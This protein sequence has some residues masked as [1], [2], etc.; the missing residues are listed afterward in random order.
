MPQSAQISTA[1]ALIIGNEIL[2]G[3]T[4][5]ANLNVIA[6]KL[7]SIG[8]RFLEARV[9]PDVEDEII[10]AVNAL[11]HR[12]TYV[13]TTGGIGPTHD[14][15]TALSI[16]KAFDLPLIEH[17]DARSR[18]LAYYTTANLNEAR[19][20]MARMPKGAALIDNPI[21]AAPGFQIGNVYVLAGVPNIMQAMMDDVATKLC[22]GPTILSTT[23]TTSVAESLIAED[24]TNIANRYQAL[25]I[26]SYPWFRSGQYGLSLVV[27]GIDAEAVKAAT[28]AI[29][30]M[31]TIHG[32]TPMIEP[33]P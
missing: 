19:L 29:C 24:L 9:I 22:H 2:S 14:D 7:M 31:I 13:F 3:R 12:Y 8:I 27:R 23:I 17:P 4:Q 25:D 33:I 28:D 16:A 15:I 20:R 5:D 26:G 1:A 32:A 30:N 18:L 6:K 10:S 21:S 11:R